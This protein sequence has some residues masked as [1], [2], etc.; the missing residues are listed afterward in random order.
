ME[1]EMP[2][3]T[4]LEKRELFLLVVSTLAFHALDQLL[5]VII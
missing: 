1:C 2:A 4:D 5:G 3:L